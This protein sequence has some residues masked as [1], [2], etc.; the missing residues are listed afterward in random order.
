MDI[1]SPDPGVLIPSRPKKVDS[2]RPDCGEGAL[3]RG[4]VGRRSILVLLE[5]SKTEVW[6]VD[7]SW[8]SWSFPQAG[9]EWLRLGG[10]RCKMVGA[11]KPGQ[12]GA[13][14]RIMVDE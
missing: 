2:S 9:L 7:P 5:A 14:G 3:A 4:K 12:R 8:L 13:G 10:R 6:D 11:W 1:A